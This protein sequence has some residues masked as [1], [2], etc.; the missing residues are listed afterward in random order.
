MFERAAA[1]APEGE[2]LTTMGHAYVEELLPDRHAVLMQMQGYVAT[3]DPEIQAH[4]RSCYRD[5]VQ[6][7]VTALRVHARRGLELLRPRDAAQRR[8]RARPRVGRGR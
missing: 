6:F 8:R 5:L 4:V 2:V 3:S 1:S 7:V